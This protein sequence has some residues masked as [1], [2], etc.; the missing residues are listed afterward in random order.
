[1]LKVYN[2]SNPADV[3]PLPIDDD[4]RYVTHKYNGYDELNFE[5]ESNSSLYRYIIEE[6]KIEDEK[7]RYIIKSIDEHSDFVTVR[8]DIDLDDWKAEIIYEYRRTR[9][10]LAQVL[11]EIIPDGWSIVW[12]CIAPAKV[13][14][15]EGI[16]G[17]PMVAV[18]PLDIL[19][20]AAETWSV[21]FNFEVL[22]KTLKVIDPTSYLTSGIFFTD[23]LNLKSIGFVG[24]SD[25][26]A[27]RL[28]AFGA[29]DADGNPTTFADINDG[30]PYV[31]DYTHSDKVVCVGWSDE[32]YSVKENLLEAAKQKL[33]QISTPA[34]SYDCNA[35]D[36]KDKVWM[37]KVVTLVDR[38][39]RTRVDHQIVEWKEYKDHNL[40]T[41]TLSKTAPSI[42]TYVSSIK[43]DLDESVNDVFSNMQQ[44]IDEAVSHATEKITGNQGG[45]FLWVFDGE[46]KPT[47]LLNL[48]DSDDINTA[49]SIWRW[50]ASGLGHSNDG[51]N[52]AY[53]MAILAD[54]SINANA[55]TTGTLTANIIKAGTLSDAEGNTSWDL[56]TGEL[57]SKKLSINSENFKLDMNGNV[58]M[59]NAI[60]DGTISSRGD[61]TFDN[62]NGLTE[63][64]RYGFSMNGQFETYVDGGTLSFKWLDDGQLFSSEQVAARFHPEALDWSKNGVY[65]NKIEYFDAAVGM[66]IDV[67]K[68]FR[69]KDVYKG[70]NFEIIRYTGPKYSETTSP[71]TTGHDRR[72]LILG[73]SDKDETGFDTYVGIIGEDVYLSEVS[74][75]VAG[76]FFTIKFPDEGYAFTGD[77]H[78]SSSYDYTI[79][80]NSGIITGWS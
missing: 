42:V 9:H 46:G 79:H 14:T 28:Y 68:V 75:I 8:C 26:F 35:C 32:R 13:T 16:Q 5:I 41:I 36:L 15:I 63:M 11:E 47:E 10:R 7:N 50:N 67:S 6:A 66:G 1:M 65:G 4:K 55:I 76:N 71:G 45:H 44:L 27:T 62:T 19:S 23:E 53:T 59:S 78:V 54:G 37:Y 73:G 70:S 49:K 60:M 29:K 3:I 57:Y 64:T 21:V 20:K 61:F 2:P 43:S 77:L 74:D 52:G 12:E 48:C 38:V 25:G 80:V 56:V 34:R 33:S 30:K 69:L 22:S 72:H 40:D 17:Q 51:Y 24:S 18:T 39:R 31:E 58:Q